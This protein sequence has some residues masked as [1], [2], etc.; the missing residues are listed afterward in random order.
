M[1]NHK[2][3]S[4]RR[5]NSNDGI[6]SSLFF[7]LTF[8][9]CSMNASAGN[10][11]FIQSTQ[12]NDYLR[13]FNGGGGPVFFD[14]NEIWAHEKWTEV[15]L[16]GGKYAYQ[17]S[18]GKYLRAEG[19]GWGWFS[20]GRARCDR[21]SIGSH[22]K[23]TKKH[24][25]N[26]E[27]ALKCKN[28]RYLKR[29]IGEPVCI[30]S[31]V[32]GDNKFKIA[33]A[34]PHH[35]R[36][37][38]SDPGWADMKLGV[39]PGYDALLKADFMKCGIPKKAF[40]RSVNQSVLQGLLPVVGTELT[41]MFLKNPDYPR[42]EGSGS[43]GNDVNNTW[44]C[45]T[46]EGDNGSEVDVVNFTCLSCHGSVV[47]GTNQYKLGLP[48]TQLDYGMFFTPELLE[49]LKLVILDQ[50]DDI[51]EYDK[52][53]D[54]VRAFQDYMGTSTLGAN[55]AIN[56]GSLIWAFRDGLNPD[57]NGAWNYDKPVKEL[58]PMMA[59]VSFSD[60]GKLYYLD[61]PAL[62]TTFKGNPDRKTYH[63]GLNSFDPGSAFATLLCGDDYDTHKELQEDGFDETITQIL[64]YMATITSPKIEEYH[65][66]ANPSSSDVKEGKT[67][68]NNNCSSCHGTYD[69][70]DPA[71]DN[72]KL[73]H[74]NVGT[75]PR[76]WEMQSSDE[77]G[78]PAQ[79][80]PNSVFWD[81]VYG[82]S[83]VSP[84]EHVESDWD[85]GGYPE[86][87]FQSDYAAYKA[88]YLR[89]VWATAP[90]LHN[91]SVPDLAQLFEED[92]DRS[93]YWRRFGNALA[94]FQ[95]IG[96]DVSHGNA[97]WKYWDE[98]SSLVL[99][100]KVFSQDDMW[101]VPLE[102]KY[103]YDTTMDGHSNSG[104]NYGTRLSNSDKEKLIEYLKS[105]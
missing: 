84:W 101:A 95:A 47:P 53:I 39:D 8:L 66:E 105:L 37:Q 3:L 46:V 69:D 27:Y 9:V 73:D 57:N 19:G 30:D 49:M 64:D 23:W 103:V 72:Y 104:H 34:S 4:N 44:A 71:L 88:P 85:N 31:R 12:D 90:Y 77:F 60:K 18:N 20:L 54:T 26:G 10:T 28:G 45:T 89:G 48:A 24:L 99:G 91:G 1:A 17:C 68:Y 14:R 96:Y 65:P 98:N 58:L 15:D 25:G 7:V 94:K 38:P 80:K 11:V 93:V 41:D 35:G 6:V 29:T 21:S 83:D 32:N 22:E 74:F 67:I 50:K 13:A 52:F 56:L 78:I 61:P 16:G 40:D 70:N 82:D 59:D 79:W 5:W 36:V 33:A 100:Q 81:I 75:D 2:N 43:C 62:W 76:I 63:T 86:G 92:A 87:F 102:R 97:G 55:P 42:P 51:A